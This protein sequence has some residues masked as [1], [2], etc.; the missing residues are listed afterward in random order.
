MKS[1]KMFV[2][3]VIATPGRLLDLVNRN[4]FNLKRVTSLVLDEAD[5]ML[6]LG[7]MPDARTIIGQTRPDR[8]TGMFSATWPPTVKKLAREFL[9]SKFV[10]VSVGTLK[11]RANHDISQTVIVTTEREKMKSLLNILEKIGAVA[12]TANAVQKTHER[13]LI[14]CSRKV[15]CEE[16][17]DELWRKGFSVDCIH[18]GRNQHERKSALSKF[19]EG[20]IPILVATDVAAR[21]LDVKELKY[22][23]N[24]HMPRCSEDYIHRIGRCGRAGKKGFAFT[25]FSAYDARHARSLVSILEEAKETIPSQLREWAI[26]TLTKS[27]KRDERKKKRNMSSRDYERERDFGKRQKR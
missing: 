10:E 26:N 22:V 8:V 19:E 24:L 18:G 11:P 20:V 16:V 17:A 7:F 27:E 6:D 4:V 15:H 13:V 9:G 12:V 25:L 1:T 14:F 3:I 5:R 21:G 23:V 2:K